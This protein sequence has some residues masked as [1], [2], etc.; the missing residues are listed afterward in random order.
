MSS[1]A[2]VGLE[3]SDKKTPVNKWELYGW[4]SYNVAVNAFSSVAM[5]IFFPLLLLL[6]AEAHAWLQA[7]DSKPPNCSESV[8]IN[9]VKCIPG[10]GDQLVTAAGYQDLI[11][12]MV[13]AGPLA[14]NPVS[15]A[16]IIIGVAVIC[17]VFAL[18]SFGPFTDYGTGRMDLLKVGT[19]IG[20]IPSIVIGVL[21]DSSYWWFAGLLVI[22]AN[23][24]YGLCTVSYN[25]Y[26]P[27]LVD[28]TPA[29][30]HAEVSGDK[31]KIAAIR[32][33]VENR[34][35]LIGL[36]AG[37][38]ADVVA[39][40]A[41]FV[42]TLAATTDLLKMRL[43]GAFC[44][45]WWLV[46]SV[47]T[48][49]WLRTRPGPPPPAS[50]TAGGA[51]GNA[52]L[53]I[54]ASW[55]HMGA[56]V[57]EARRYRNAFVFMLCYFIYADGFST[58]IQVGVLFGQHDLCVEPAMLA[59]IATSVSFWAALGMPLAYY[60]QKRLGWNNKTMVVAL[61]T[62]MLP[63]PLWGLLGY[64]TPDGG[65]GLKASWELF[66][67]SG[68]FGFCLGP[69]ISYSRTLFVDLI[70]KGRE[71]AFFSLYAISDK[72]SSWLGPFVVAAI[73]QFTGKIRPA[74][75]YIFV[76]MLVPIFFLNTYLDYSQGL[77]ESGRHDGHG[78]QPSADDA[79]ELG[80]EERVPLTQF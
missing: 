54:V 79:A 67:Y 20:V 72:G 42:I 63:L 38:L 66:A 10:R 80:E 36:A 68:W 22:I 21:G 76:V 51:G 2:S 70:P 46:F 61:L 4:Y 43:A 33:Q 25:S 5:P 50:A 48:F 32:E 56:L 19:L 28:A 15:Y 60:L 13:H 73:A 31:E 65:L 69:L 39:T 11:L 3:P 64:F 57:S 41:A 7:G 52:A 27:V 49:L 59:V 53:T 12:P 30:M 74:F 24:G 77:K 78:Q 62:T 1:L 16:T 17:Q 40:L 29:V 8:S 6:L 34:I 71:G 14:V 23:V 55:R 26:L 9:C 45:L 75:L 44:G 47:F 18:I 35:S 58:V 37:C